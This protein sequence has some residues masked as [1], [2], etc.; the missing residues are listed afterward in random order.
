MKCPYCKDG[1]NYSMERFYSSK[2]GMYAETIKT[3]CRTCKGTGKKEKI[4]MDHE[5]L[6]HKI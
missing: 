5:E 2:R 1:F 3:I 4:K 6:R